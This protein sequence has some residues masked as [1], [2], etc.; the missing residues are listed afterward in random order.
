MR[1]EVG[2]RRQSDADVAEQLGA[3]AAGAARDQR[4]E[5]AGPARRRRSARRL[6]APSPARGSRRAR[7]RPSRPRASSARPRRPPAPGAVRPRTAARVALVHEPG[8]DR[9]QRDAATELARRAR[10][11][12]RVGRDVADAGVAHAV[13]VE[14][15]RDVVGARASRLRPRARCAMTA[16]ASSGRAV[17]EPRNRADWRVT[18]GAVARGVT[19]RACRVLGEGEAR[20]SARPPR[21]SSSSAS[22]G[23]EHRREGRRPAG[24]APPPREIAAATSTASVT[25]GGTKIAMI[26]S[27]TPARPTASIARG[28]PS[29]RRGRDHVDRVR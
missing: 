25:S 10:R 2:Q 18:P 17:G 15:L 27:T 28:S 1:V 20:P 8:R 19:E 14:Q 12:A 29:A 4:A 6:A 7:S 16:A 24:R 21:R 26:A 5:R 13:A 11:V 3:R 9:L 23:H 22:L